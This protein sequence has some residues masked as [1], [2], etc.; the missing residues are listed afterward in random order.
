MSLTES[1]EEESFRE[2]QKAKAAAQGVT[3]SNAVPEQRPVASQRT[4]PEQESKAAR[5]RDARGDNDPM[6]K[7][8]YDKANSS[9]SAAKAKKQEQTMG[10]ETLR[11]G[12]RVRIIKGDY[13]GSTGAITQVEYASFEE[14]QR[15]SSGDPSVVRFAKA[16]SYM[17]RTRG[18]AHALVNV[19]PKDIVE[20]NLL[21]I[22]QSE[23]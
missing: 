7:S 3:S 8:A 15:A 21:G 13:E 14:S 11:E 17:V 19:K 23:A 9:R 18:G 20:I 2:D 12:A 16:A 22:N 4:V 6:P 1:Q 5:M 10:L